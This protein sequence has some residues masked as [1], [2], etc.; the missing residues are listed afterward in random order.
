[1]RY[2]NVF[3]I[4]S[5]CLSTRTPSNLERAILS[6]IKLKGPITVADYMK[7]ALS[8]PIWVFDIKH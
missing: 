2:R 8:N 1:M 3:G 7:E 6:R 4:L 5:R